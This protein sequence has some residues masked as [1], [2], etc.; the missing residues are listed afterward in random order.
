MA[1]N[2]KI[3]C[4]FGIQQDVTNNLVT[5]DNVPHRQRVCS[6]KKKKKKNESSIFKHNVKIFRSSPSCE[7]R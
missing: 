7:I 6:Q 3:F 1:L 4:S 5:G 2:V